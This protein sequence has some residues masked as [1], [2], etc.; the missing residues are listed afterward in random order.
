MSLL[1]N[2]SNSPDDA[3]LGKDFA[4]GTSHVVL[5]AIVAGLMMTAAIAI[6]F[7]YIS[8][9]KPAPAVG[10]VTNIWAYPLHT[11]TP[12]MDA[13]GVATTS[14]EYDQVLIFAQVRVHNQSKNPLILHQVLANIKMDDGIHSS[15]AA[16]LADYQRIYI[17]YPQLSSLHDQP[18]PISSTLD[19]GQTVQGMMICAYRMPW[20]EWAKHKDL[21]FTFAFRYQPTLTLTPTVALQMPTS[22]PLQQAPPPAPVK[23][24]KHH[25]H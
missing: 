15:Y 7:L 1:Q 22:V 18:F 13:S 16:D 20:A 6:Y 10:E 11:R 25:G 2:D 23:P 24:A 19:P 21:N 12:D 5:A 8:G 14:E 17:A 4:Q 9:Q 3:A